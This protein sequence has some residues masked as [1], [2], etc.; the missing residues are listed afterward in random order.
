LSQ[1]TR[2]AKV[3]PKIGAERS[4]LLNETKLRSLTET[5]NLTE[6]TGYLRESSYQTQISKIALP[7][8][9]RKLEHAL[10]ENLIETYI[11]IIKNSPKKTAHLLL[12]YLSRFEIENIKVL[13]KATNANL[14]TEEKQAKLYSTIEIYLKKLQ[15]FENISKASTLKQIVTTLRKTEY[16]PAL[17]MGL[18][19]FEEEGATTCFN[20]LLDKHYYESLWQVFQ[21]LPKKEKKHAFFYISLEVDIY[22]LLMLLRG[23]L[24][25]YDLNWLRVAV[26]GK[27]IQLPDTLVEDM[28]CST[29]FDSALK[30]I[31]RTPYSKYFTKEQTPNETI[32]KAE[33]EVDK[34]LLEYI[35]KNRIME[36][37][38]VGVVLSFLLQKKF[39]I[40]NLIT[41]S[42]CIE[43]EKKPEDIVRHLIL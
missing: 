12:I 30:L 37:F 36:I 11:K 23:K 31:Q 1:T 14:T 33:N 39:E 38:N 32:A 20:V 2:Y 24:L 35:K 7:I 6:I 18:Q 3:L 19:S 26:P 16:A 29:D 28:V 13:I 5:K 9:S 8:S 43:A 27:R 15:L 17:K 40:R 25:E 21:D 41:I 42:L 4:Q 10:N 22:I 34:A